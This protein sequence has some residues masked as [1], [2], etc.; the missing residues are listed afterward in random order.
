[1]QMPPGVE[2]NTVFIAIA[3]VLAAAVVKGTTGFGFA[4]VSTPL[5]LLFWEPK[6]LVPI[7]L[8][9]S[10][11]ADVLI[12]AQTWRRVEWMKVLPLITAGIAGVPVGVYLLTTV[13]PDLLKLMV[14]GIAMSMAILMLMGIT[15]A[16]S[17]E[18]LASVITGF[19]SGVLSTSTTM[20]GPPVALLMINQRWEKET[21]RACLA[22]FFLVIQITGIL[23]LTILGNI[24]PSTLTVSIALWPSVIVG[25]L[26]AIK[27]LSR[28]PQSTFIRIATVLVMVT[29]TVVIV[30]TALNFNI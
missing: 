21:F 15:I 30:E 14:S 26:I 13:P 24:T 1:M 18:K 9:L 17:R 5:L 22:M 20:S 10:I 3:I 2:P 29:A 6:V 28:L 16:I 8:P 23:Y 11:I 25:N 4:L 7:F 27:I 12:V 19:V